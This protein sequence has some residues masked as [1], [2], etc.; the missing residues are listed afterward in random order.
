MLW[1]VCHLVVQAIHNIRVCQQEHYIKE[2]T[3]SI[4]L[5]LNALTI[6]RSN[7]MEPIDPENE[8]AWTVECAGKS[9]IPGTPNSDED[10][11]RNWLSEEGSPL[12][13]SLHDVRILVLISHTNYS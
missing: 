8:E 7:T 3:E 5:P 11:P 12:K 4:H 2:S 1:V 6:F 13:C 9:I 10:D